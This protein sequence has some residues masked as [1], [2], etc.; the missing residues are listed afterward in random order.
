MLILKSTRL[1]LRSVAFYVGTFLTATLSSLAYAQTPREQLL[2][3]VEVQTDKK[4]YKVNEPIKLKYTLIVQSATGTKVDIESLNYPPALLD[5][6]GP[7]GEKLTSVRRPPHTARDGNSRDVYFAPAAFHGLNLDLQQWYPFFPMIS[8]HNFQVPGK[9]KI[10]GVFEQKMVRTETGGADT[11]AARPSLPKQDAS[12]KSGTDSQTSVRY[13]SE[14]IEI[15]IDAP[16]GDNI[17]KLKADLRQGKDDVLLKAMAQV[18]KQELTELLPLIEQILNNTKKIKVKQTA[19]VVLNEMAQARFTAT[20][21]RNLT[22]ADDIVRSEMALALRPLLRNKQL[23]G[24]VIDNAVPV[25]LMMA[26]RQKYPD[27]YMSAFG[28]L[29][30]ITD[31]RIVPLATQIAES[32]PDGVHRVIAKQALARNKTNGQ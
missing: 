7:K 26:D 12:S 10:T 14:P 20:Y 31:P 27:S 25:L 32:D 2:L 15:I 3:R 24:K 13:L 23:E 11:S 16:S 30:L 19:T 17:E 18:R 1:N 29:A 4:S 6:V 8:A 28:T 22:D 9:Y 5:V 21:I